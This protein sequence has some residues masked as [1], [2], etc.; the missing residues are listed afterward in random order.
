M[1]DLTNDKGELIRFNKGFII[2]SWKHQLHMG[3]CNGNIR[4][5]NEPMI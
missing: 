5:Y 3:I 2:K 1:V 4:E